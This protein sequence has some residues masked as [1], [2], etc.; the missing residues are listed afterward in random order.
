MPDQPFPS[1]QDINNARARAATDNLPAMT[2]AE[3]DALNG[4]FIILRCYVAH[5]KLKP[6]FRAGQKIDGCN[7]AGSVI[8]PDTLYKTL[9]YIYEVTPPTGMDPLKPFFERKEAF[10]EWNP[11]RVIHCP[12]PADTGS[13]ASGRPDSHTEN[14]FVKDKPFI[15]WSE[16]EN[17]WKEA[18]FSD[19]ERTLQMSVNGKESSTDHDRRSFILP[20]S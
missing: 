10:V 7:P 18:A 20:K 17:N 9:F 8:K 13:G 6:C 16:Q 15:Y 4:K 11:D 1:L 14:Y 3:F 19:I 5:S 12:V 2:Q